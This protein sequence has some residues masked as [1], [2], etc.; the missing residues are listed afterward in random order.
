MVVV[1]LVSISEHGVLTLIAGM[2]KVTS[3]LRTKNF[4]RPP[5][6]A[7]HTT[8]LTLSSACN[9]VGLCM[10]ERHGDQSF[11]NICK[12]FSITRIFDIGQS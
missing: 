12:V 8:P 4:T 1:V 5:D 2:L 9:H 3:W 7:W 11:S 6:A 10:S